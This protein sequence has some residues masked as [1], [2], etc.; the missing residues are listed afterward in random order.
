MKHPIR[1]Q[2]QVSRNPELSVDQFTVMQR[3]RP[4]LIMNGAMYSNSSASNSS[5]LLPFESTP[6]TVGVRMTFEGQGPG[7]RDIG[8]GMI[9]RAGI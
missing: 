9:E 7:G 6:I 4:F 1:I 2:S 5:Q 3:Q 8:G